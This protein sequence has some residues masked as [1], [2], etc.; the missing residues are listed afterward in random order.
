MELQLPQYIND[1]IERLEA[2]GH[3]AYAVGGCVRD[4][5]LGIEPHDYDVCTSALPD[6]TESCFADMRVI[7]TGKKHGTVTV[8]SEQPVEITTY[9]TDGDYT[10]GRHPDSVTFVPDI[11]GDLARRDFTVNAMAFSEKRG[12]VDLFGGRKDLEAGTIRCVGDPSVR[13]SEDALRILR[14]LRFASTYGFII[15]NETSRA[16]H[17]MKD[18]LSAVSA[19]RIFEETTKLLLGVSAADI[20]RG[21]ADVLCVYIPEI[22]PTVGFAQQT[23]HHHLDVWEH[24]LCALDVC[25]RERVMRWAALLHDV[26]KPACFTKDQAGGHFHGHPAVSERIA[27][28]ILTRLHC[29]GKTMRSVCSLIRNHDDYFRGGRIEMRKYISRLG[30]ELAGLVLEFRVYDCIA[31]SP[32]TR[33]Q[34]LKDL[35]AARELYDRVIAEKDCTSL[36]SLDVNGDDIV[37]HGIEPG[38]RVK[39]ALETLLDA[40]MSDNCPNEKQALINYLDNNFN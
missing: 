12:F 15:E 7:L 35:E 10:D 37:D 32:V 30:E 25:R 1:I 16:I 2:C 11:A 23:R 20:L 26:G 14:A 6:E 38:K 33:E 13:F 31:Q 24:T 3:E 29:D 21:Y 39:E 8:L 19:E 36:S 5:L 17:D 40:V 9:R 22:K 28:D 18:S 27:R 34:K 4:M